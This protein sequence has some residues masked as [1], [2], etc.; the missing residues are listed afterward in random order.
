MP[1]RNQG[2][3]RS[4]DPVLEKWMR[5]SARP[6]DAC[7][8]V[9]ESLAEG[10]A[11]DAV[12][13]AHNASGDGRRRLLHCRGDDVRHRGDA[14][15]DRDTGCRL[16]RAFTHDKRGPRMAKAIGAWGSQL[17]FYT[18]ARSSLFAFF[19][20]LNSRWLTLTT[21]NTTLWYLAS[22][23]HSKRFAT[24]VLSADKVDSL[25]LCLP[26]WRANE[27]AQS[28]FF[29]RRTVDVILVT[30]RI[31]G[32]TSRNPRQNDRVDRSG[33]QVRRCGWRFLSPL[34]HPNVRRL[35]I[36]QD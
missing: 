28:R 4:R 32:S 14:H 1:A 2:V 6:G 13:S 12:D 36:T 3:H 20:P 24:G 5:H 9:V 29:Y 11:T 35:W 25:P 17:S 8:S 16:V 19:G 27:T 15:V 10:H 21:Q 26:D 22:I 23:P 18:L 33:V 31:E 7:R 34:G 30:D